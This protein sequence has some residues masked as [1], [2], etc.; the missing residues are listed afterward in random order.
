MVGR[1]TQVCNSQRDSPDPAS[2]DPGRSARVAGG[3]ERCGAITVRR[4]Y[5]PL[6]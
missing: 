3:A 4:A 1:C 2:A 5:V 6:Q